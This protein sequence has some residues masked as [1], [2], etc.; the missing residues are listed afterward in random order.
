M[1]PYERIAAS[2]FDIEEPAIRAPFR[3]RSWRVTVL[4]G[5]MAAAAVL[6]TNIA[7]LAWTLKMELESKDGIVTVYRGKQN[8]AYCCSSL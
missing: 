1:G 8:F 7:L 6:L 2:P 5:A 4:A 3:W